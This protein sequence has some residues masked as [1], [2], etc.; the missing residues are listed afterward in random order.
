MLKQVWAG[1]NPNSQGD[2]EKSSHPN[3]ELWIV[4]WSYPHGSEMDRSLF[5][6]NSEKSVV[7]AI[8][9]NKSKARGTTLPDFKLYYKP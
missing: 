7:L 5:N 8:L 2:L 3:R 6:I 4:H 1:I 9:I